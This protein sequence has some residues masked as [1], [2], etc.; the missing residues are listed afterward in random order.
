MQ[1][2]CAE[3]LYTERKKNSSMRKGDEI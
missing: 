1:D 2:V 3:I